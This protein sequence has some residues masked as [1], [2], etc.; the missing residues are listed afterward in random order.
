MNDLQIV[1]YKGVRVVTTRQVAEMYGTNRSIISK[2]FNRNKRKFT[3]GKHYFKLSGNELKN[4]LEFTELQSKE[5]C[6]SQNDAYKN[7]CGG[8]NDDYKN[9]CSSE[10]ASQIS[11]KTR[12]L[13]L[14]TNRG[15]LLLAKIIDTDVAWEAYERLV[16]FYF[17]V[18]E[19]L[20]QPDGYFPEGQPSITYQTSSTPVP[21]NP[22]WYRRNRRR[23]EYICTQ[24]NSSMSSLY[25][26]ILLRLGEEY[27]LDAANGIYEKEV[28]HVPRY[29][30]D[31]VSYFPE[32]ARMADD[33]LDKIEKHLQSQEKPL[34]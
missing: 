15:A 1:E 6:G 23:M 18:K 28:G 2:D 27:N 20:R 14:W 7:I 8:Q 13:Y 5:I 3:E 4:F 22:S 31:I 32:L 12:V 29:A 19:G 16:D 26:L 11:N 9:L 17:E 10:R 25:H 30:M 34:I 21:K 24:A 33:L